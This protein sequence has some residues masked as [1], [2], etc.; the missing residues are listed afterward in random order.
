MLDAYTHKQERATQKLRHVSARTWTW[1]ANRKHSHNRR[2]QRSV[3]NSRH[4]HNSKGFDSRVDAGYE[5]ENNR[6]VSDRRGDPVMINEP[7]HC[8]QTN[9][10]QADETLPK[11][12]KYT[13][14]TITLQNRVDCKG[15]R[16]SLNRSI[17]KVLLVCVRSARLGRMVLVIMLEK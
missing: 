9:K 2:D 16:H 6:S 11:I 1:C 13:R 10:V 12:N 14:S 4:G 15:F 8:H 5:P 7:C 17:Q 3:G